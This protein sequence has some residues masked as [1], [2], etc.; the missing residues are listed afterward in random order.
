MRLKLFKIHVE[1]KFDAV[2]RTVRKELKGYKIGNVRMISNRLDKLKI[3][4][5]KTRRDVKIV[6]MK[7][8]CVKPM[9]MRWSRQ[10]LLIMKT[11]EEKKLEFVIDVLVK[12]VIKLR[13]R[14]RRL[15]KNL[16][17]QCNPSRFS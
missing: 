10:S 14:V 2:R 1:K 15:Q 13:R 11:R 4:L 5:K 16:R 7:R 8:L 12:H 9:M 6:K 17:R 3:G